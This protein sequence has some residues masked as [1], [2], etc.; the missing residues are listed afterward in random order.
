MYT[1]FLKQRHSLFASLEI[2][3]ET[4]LAQA[5]LRFQV[6]SLSL[7]KRKLSW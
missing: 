6:F 2:L 4:P 3:H 7:M 1:V 5:L